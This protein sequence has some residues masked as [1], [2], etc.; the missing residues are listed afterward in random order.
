MTSVVSI[1]LLMGER[2][3]R[4]RDKARAKQRFVAIAFVVVLF[5]G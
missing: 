4:G 5:S 2:E 3:R 1:Y